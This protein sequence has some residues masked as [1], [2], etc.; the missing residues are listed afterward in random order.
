MKPVIVA[1]D[2]DAQVLS[3]VRRDLRSRYGGDYRIVAAD[4]G[5]SALE[6]LTELLGRGAVV[7]LF[8]VDQRMPAMSGT[9]FLVEATTLFPE[10]KKVLLTAYADTE[11]AIQAINDVALDHY[12]LK[13]WDPPDEQ[14][15][16]VLDDLLADWRAN[17]PPPFDGVRVIGATW[18]PATTATKDF[19]A[20]NHVPYRFLDVDRDEEAVPVVDAHDG[21]LPVVVLPDG[22]TLVAPDSRTLA[23]ALGM[24]TEATEPLYDL[25]IVGGGP[26]GL[27]AAVYGASEGLR[28]VMVERAAPGGQASTSSRIENYLGFPAGISGGDLARRAA[29]QAQ[30]L[31]AEILTAAEVQS[32]R[33]H[34]GT[35]ILTLSDGKEISALAVV[36]ASGM[37]VRRLDVPGYERFEGAGVYYGAAIT[38]AATYTDNPVFVVGGANSAG[39]GAMLFSRYASKVTMVVRADD[40]GLRM[41]QYLID[42]I[43]GTPN[44]EVRT[45]TVVKEV[46]GDPGVETIT[47]EH[48]AT[49]EV[50]TLPTSAIFIFV[51]AVP[52]SAFVADLVSTNERGFIHTGRDIFLEGQPA[53]WDLRREPYPMET[54]VPG[55]FAA[56][57][58][59]HGV[60][61]RVASAVG[62]GS[63]VVSM[64][65]EYLDTV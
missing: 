27:A 54:S 53:T 47:V 39:Q 24:Q 60:V 1:V 12:L 49:G 32:I 51:G 41:S 58:V 63:V 15:Y 37:T 36:I 48:R 22:S 7:A 42:Q 40:L 35:K 45:G 52:H 23:D 4:S 21:T 59:R 5:A 28:T 62:Q 26:A 10:A 3:S 20:R 13:P 55:I 29:T 56:G 6:V 8:L 38:E 25:V 19:L 31:G 61:R 9:E 18:S 50:E 64:V 2:D 30:R 57:D 17:V 16:P 33:V 34:E 43:A 65:H 11:A 46:G 14:L 44:I